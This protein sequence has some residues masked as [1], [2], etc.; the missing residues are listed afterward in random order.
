MA[1]TTP[2]SPQSGAQLRVTRME[3]KL[4]QLQTD[5]GIFASQMNAEML[6]SRNRM[7]AIETMIRDREEAIRTAFDTTAA[8]RAAELASV[9]AGARSE[10][11][12]QRQQLQ[13]I[14]SAVQVEFHKLQQQVEQDSTKDGGSKGGTC[15]LPVKELKPP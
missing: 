15:F 5:Q 14:T 7:L 13:D 6:Q 3:E 9:V 1:G 12:K 2:L 8:Q 11:D 10:F 4:K